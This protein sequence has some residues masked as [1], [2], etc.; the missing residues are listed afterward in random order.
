MTSANSSPQVLTTLTTDEGR[1]V[2]GLSRTKVGGQARV[3]TALSVASLALK[4]RQNKSQHQRVVLFSCS[5]VKETKEELVKLGKKLKKTA[6]AVDVV[7][8]GDAALEEAPAEEGEGEQQTNGEAAV[9]SEPT[10]RAKWT[11]FH[12]AI[13]G[14]PD[15]EHQ[16]HLAVIPPGPNLLSD[17]LITTE[18][19][20]GMGGMGGGAGGESEGGAGGAGGSFDEYGG[21]DPNA[22]PELALALRMSMEEEERRQAQRQRE[23]QGGEGTN[24]ETVPEGNEEA[25]GDKKEGGDGGASGSGG[26][27]MDTS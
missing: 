6:V 23:E 15:A 20:E 13:K 4:H 19:M 5:E 25:G 16:S 3:A 17:A 21:I 12:N 26:D 2:H 22:D 7:V 10:T 1:L 9:K 8:M 18:V 14:P 24:L 11:A 27:R